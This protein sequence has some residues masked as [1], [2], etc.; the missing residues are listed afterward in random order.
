MEANMVGLP[1]HE[2]NIASSFLRQGR[3]NRAHTGGV[4]D[5]TELGRK[6]LATHESNER[7]FYVKPVLAVIG[8]I[9]NRA[10]EDIFKFTQGSITQWDIAVTDEKVVDLPTRVISAI[11]LEI[12]SK[13][14]AGVDVH[15]IVLDVLQLVKHYSWEVKVLL[16]L[17]TLMITFGKFRLV[18]QNYTTNPLP[19]AIAILKQLPEILEHLHDLKPTLDALF[20][21]IGEIIDTTNKLVE[22]YDLPEIIAVDANVPT[23]VYWTIR[24]IVVASTQMFS[25]T[26]SLPI[27]LLTESWELSSLAHKL[28]NIKRLHLVELLERCLTIMQEKRDEEAFR[29]LERIFTTP[30]LDNTRALSTLFHYKDG[31]PALYDCYLKRKVATE[32]L[33]NKTVALFITDMNLNL[34]RGQ[35]YKILERIYQQKKHSPMKM[36]SHYEIVWV[37][38][39][40]NWDEDKLILFETLRNQMEWHSIDHHSVV[41][42][43]VR[44]YIKEKWNFNKK[45]ILVVIDKQGA[46]VHHDATNMICIWGNTAYPFTINREKLLWE[47][48]RWSIDL[49]IDNLEPNLNAWIQE[50][51]HICLYGGEDMEWIRDFTI[52]AKKVARDAGISLE[53]V[54]VGKSQIKERVVSTIIDTIHKEKLSRTLD[55]D[56]INYF[57]LRLMRM[58][59]SKRQLAKFENTTHDHI[60]EGITVILSYDSSDYTKGRWAV[61]SKDIGH[62]VRSKGT[63]ML[64]A[65][66]EHRLWIP[67]QQEIGFVPALDEYLKDHVQPHEPHH[68]TSLVLPSTGALPDVM[69]CCDCGRLMETYTL[70]RCCLE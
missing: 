44:R 58:L 4:T 22:F 38:I 13:C 32:E 16:V 29:E 53:M 45:P 2:K 9:F 40:D 60:L 25:L 23:V 34:Q 33:S 26:G 43:V 24:S 27:D 66:T 21:L 11:S 28:N 61:M 30:H 42:T 1:K 7:G 35:E 59:E 15:T 70:F 56:H 17:V 39:V 51:R 5:D 47:E 3:S 46:V 31:Q 10:S 6:I 65:L 49:L 52:A 67:R 48:M 63:H 14:S 57:W 68:C 36:D 50:G 69:K 64:K 54:Y 19:K 20:A 62:M 12:Y 37:P 55:R 8:V 18:V 41:S